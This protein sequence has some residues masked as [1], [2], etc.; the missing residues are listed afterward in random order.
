MFKKFLKRIPGANRNERFTSTNLKFNITEEEIDEAID[1]LEKSFQVL[2]VSSLVSVGI[3]VR[4]SSGG[5]SLHIPG[6]LKKGYGVTVVLSEDNS[7]GLRCL[8][9]GMCQRCEASQPPQGGSCIANHQ[10]G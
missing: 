9:L 2:T 1:Q 8:V 4:P 10:G 3:N 7:C 5:S 6:F